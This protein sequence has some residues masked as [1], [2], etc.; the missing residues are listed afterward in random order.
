MNQG[1]D[2]NHGFSSDNLQANIR[3]RGGRGGRAGRTGRAGGRGNVGARGNNRGTARC[4][5]YS[6]Q[7]MENESN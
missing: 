5:Y 4:G 6:Y 3:G 2:K 1:N 7:G